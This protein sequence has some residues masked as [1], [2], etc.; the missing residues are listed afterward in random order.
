MSPTDRIF[1]LFK[2]QGVTAA[3]VSKATGISQG[4]FS[5]WKAGRNTPGYG[6]RAKLAEYFGVSIAYLS[7]E[8][9][10]PTPAAASSGD[11]QIEILARAA[12]KMT[13][14][15]KEKLVEMAKLLFKKAFDE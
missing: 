7:G 11:V 3:E 8:S 5:D 9:D 12:R 1:E 4:N 15:E 2:K 6:A 14:E 13:P 10:D